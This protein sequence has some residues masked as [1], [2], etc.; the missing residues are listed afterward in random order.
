MTLTPPNPPTPPTPTTKTLTTGLTGLLFRLLGRGNERVHAAV[1]LTSCATL[2]GCALV[3]AGAAAAGK[4]VSIEFAAAVGAV[5]GLA[6]WAYG[7]AKTIEVAASS[8][9]EVQGLNPSDVSNPSSAKTGIVYPQN[10]AVFGAHP[11]RGRCE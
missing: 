8:A 1:I 2:C 9:A 6:G 4:S 5:S 11:E 7:K 3:L 10:N